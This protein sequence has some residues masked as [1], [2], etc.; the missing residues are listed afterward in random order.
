MTAMSR[1]DLIWP[2]IFHSLKTTF[3]PP[4]FSDNF[5]KDFDTLMLLSRNHRVCDR[6]PCSEYF[7][8][9]NRFLHDV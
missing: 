1:Y 7:V 5:L 2:K 3:Q 4:F 8:G 6:R 9:L